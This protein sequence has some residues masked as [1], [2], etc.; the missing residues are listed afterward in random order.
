VGFY[1]NRFGVNIY[2][3]ESLK[4]LKESGYIAHEILLELMKNCTEGSTALD[5]ECLATNCIEK[6]KVKS[7]FK[8]VNG[9]KNV[10][11][12]SY[13]H[14]IVHGIPTSDYVFK[15]GDVVTVDFG[16]IVKGH[17]SD[18][19]KTFIVGGIDSQHQQLIDIT[20]KAFFA[21]FNQARVGNTL[22][23]IGFNIHK[24][25]VKVNSGNKLLHRGSLFKLF[26]KFQGHGIGN[27][28][29]ESPSVPNLGYPG[30]GMRLVKGMCIC[31]EPVTLYSS[32][33]P[34]EVIIKDSNFKELHTND[35]KPS[36][37][38]ENQLYI[39]EDGPILLTKINK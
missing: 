14:K 19:A 36:A 18:N 10:T 2:D 26:Y 25:I 24:E 31:I 1:T 22:G 34:V 17:Y 12:I 32:S 15:R 21:G 8:G 33:T 35:L 13:N 23:D 6:Y 3:S 5:V 39:S 30:K 9:Y 7:A 20:E 38:F 27:N 28:L 29:H 37:H 4:Y 16:V 11:C